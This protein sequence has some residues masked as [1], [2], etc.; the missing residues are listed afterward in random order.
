MIRSALTHPFSL[1]PLEVPP[2][3]SLIY[4]ATDHNGAEDRLEFR[5]GVISPV[6][7]EE[8]P[9]SSQELRGYSNYPNPFHRSTHLV[10]DLPWPAQVQVD[11]MGVTGRRLVSTPP[12]YLPAGWGHKMQLRD[13]N[14][15]SVPYLYRIQATSLED[16][17]FSVYMGYFMRVK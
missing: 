17:S 15:P 8:T 4:K 14:V 1:P 5:I 9:E 2:P 12:V 11:V 3:I 16:Q 7:T 10:F 6:D 13:L